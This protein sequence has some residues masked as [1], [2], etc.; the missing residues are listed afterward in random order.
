MTK[1]SITDI[2][3]LKITDTNQNTH[4]GGNQEW[5][6]KV[7]RRLAG[8]GPTTSSNI[9][10]YLER[11]LLCGSD[12]DS[13][14]K[15]SFIALMNEVWNFVTPTTRGVN[16]T[17]ILY[18]G[19]VKYLGTKGLEYSHRVLDVPEDVTRRKDFGE[20]LTFLKAALS[21]NTP[22]AFLNLHNGLEERL[23]R[24]H[25][26]T[27]TGL[28]VSDGENSTIAN[29]LDNGNLIQIDLSLWYKTTTLGGGFV[30]VVKN[31]GI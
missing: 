2:E 11:A 28:D 26:V 5:Y 21:E 25:W 31:G 3:R 30:Y 22:V 14:S 24:W 17:E 27:L 9:V 10:M 29:I 8:C 4:Y 13:C 6:G 20:V 15:E 1:Y 7:W 19:L 23:D 12:V 18:T 16:K